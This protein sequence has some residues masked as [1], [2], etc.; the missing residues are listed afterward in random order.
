MARPNSNCY[1]GKF[2]NEDIIKEYEKTPFSARNARIK[3]V[4][5]AT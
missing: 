2:Q 1:Y 3:L 4:V 5:K